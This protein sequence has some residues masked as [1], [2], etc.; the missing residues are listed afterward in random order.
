MAIIW[1][2]K[3]AI[4]KRAWMNIFKKT[5]SSKTKRN[6]LSAKKHQR[7]LL[8]YKDTKGPYCQKKLLALLPKSPP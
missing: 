2:N 5:L 1:N 3:K 4:P 6:Q 8:D 7:E